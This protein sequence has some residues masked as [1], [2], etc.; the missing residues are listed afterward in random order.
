MSRALWNSMARAGFYNTCSWSPSTWLCH[1]RLSELEQLINTLSQAERDLR[2]KAVRKVPRI[3]TRGD[4]GN[5]SE[6]FGW[7][8][9]HDPTRIFLSHSLVIEKLR[10]CKHKQNKELALKICLFFLP[11]LMFYREAAS[12]TL[13]CISKVKEPTQHYF[14]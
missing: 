14:Y 6:V 2:R 9:A 1:H 5:Q 4:E 12:E 13:Y 8:E 3:N 10:C 7:I 11:L